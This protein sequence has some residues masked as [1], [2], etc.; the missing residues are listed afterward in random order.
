MSEIESKYPL[1]RKEQTTRTEWILEGKEVKK[2]TF[3]RLVRPAKRLETTE[4]IDAYIKQLG[5]ARMHY[6]NM[7]DLPYCTEYAVAVNH[8]L[9]DYAV[10][11]QD[12]LS[13][14]NDRALA[15]KIVVDA[16]LIIQGELGEL[17]AQNEA[18]SSPNE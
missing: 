15:K 6:S 12:F 1:I 17:P 2:Q 4:E 7:M 13:A 8:P 18:I 14:K 10:Q 5:M 11:Q 9:H 3:G 16:D